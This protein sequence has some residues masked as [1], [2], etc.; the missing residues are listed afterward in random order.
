MP[1]KKLIRSDFLPYHV[2]ARSNN[3]ETFPVPIEKLW[4]IVEDECLALDWLYDAEI[5]AFVLMPNHFHML[6]TTPTFDLGKVMN[7]FMS[8]VTRAANQFAGRSGHVFGGPYYWSII[9]SS[10]YY[11]HAFKYVYRN[12]VKAGICLKAEDYPYST[13]RGIFGGS[14]S[15]FPIEFS[16]SALELNL[17]IHESEAM[18]NWLNRPFPK[19]AEELIARGMKLRCFE[20]LKNRSTRKPYDELG[21]LL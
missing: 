4:R 17:P 13:L 5:H 16:R 20:D 2:T 1:R 7:I 8:N 15:A 10:R 11:G 12:P 9:Q 3:R 21:E 14:R 6:I 18:L 19:E